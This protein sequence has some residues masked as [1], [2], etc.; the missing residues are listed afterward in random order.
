MQLMTNSA[1]NE[2]DAGRAGLSFIL[3]PEPWLRIFLRNVADLFRSGPPPVWLTAHPAQYWPDALVHRPA[4]WTAIRQSSFAHILAMLLVYEFTQFWV[5]Q[6]QVISVTPRHTVIHYQLSEYLPAVNPLKKSPTPP[7]RRKAQ[8]ADPEYAAQEIISIHVDHT[9][10]RQTIIQPDLSILQQDVPLPN[11][12]VSISVPGAPV[13]SRH[14][15]ANLLDSAPQVVP[16][17]EKTAP[18]RRLIFPAVPKPE[19]VGPS[20]PPTTDHAGPILPMNGPIVVQPSPKTVVRDPSRLQIPAQA[21]E[22]AP[23]ASGVAS[24]HMFG[25]PL[26]AVAPEVVPPAQQAAGRRGS[27]GL[28]LSEQPPTVVPPPQPI[29]AGPGENQSRAAGQILA[30]NAHPVVPVAPVII[31]PGNRQGEFAAGPEGRPGATARPETR[32]GDVPSDSSRGGD[33]SS[34]SSIYVSAPPAK[35]TGN[36]VMAAPAARFAVPDRTDLPPDKIDN[37][38]FG[39]RN[40]YSMKLGMTNLNSTLSSWTMRFAELHAEPGAPGKLSSPDP[41]KKVDPAYPASM[42]HDRIEGVVVL[43]AVIHTDGT[44]GEVRVLDGFNERL[45]ENAR[46]ALEQWRFRPGT[47]NGVPVEVEAVVRVPFRVPKQEF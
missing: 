44:V 38:I 22:V 29:S 21:P 36:V 42:V 19:I 18:A 40:R 10:K 20:S 17:A 15:M 24:G 8:T 13:A 28:A 5:D 32:A 4:P 37:Q 23:P 26:P 39:S 43:Y 3:E 16:P 46:V 47:R 31:P 6:P 2:L 11:M 14:A 25:Q 7:L 35:V 1:P 41:I 34:S 30:L 27:P 12:M 45:D 33:S 9:S